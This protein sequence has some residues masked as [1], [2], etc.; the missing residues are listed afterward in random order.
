MPTR[1]SQRWSSARP[2]LPRFAGLPSRFALVAAAAGLLSACQ[3]TGSTRN[4]RA[5]QQI[6]SETL[7]LMADKGTNERAPILIRAYKKEAE[8]EIW[9]MKDD[10]HYTLLKTYPMCR[11]WPA[12]TQDSRR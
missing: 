5:F 4:S 1:L 3:D 12:R 10:G 9:K 6:S 11:W 2:L 8:L 7:D